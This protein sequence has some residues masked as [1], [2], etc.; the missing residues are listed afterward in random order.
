MRCSFGALY[1][2]RYRHPKKEVVDRYR[3]LGV[4]QM[5]TD[6]A[7]AIRL[8]SADGLVAHAFRTEQAR[9]WHGR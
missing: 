8:D 4:A 5:R 6:Q 1:R 9:Y 7:G 2:Y 3:A